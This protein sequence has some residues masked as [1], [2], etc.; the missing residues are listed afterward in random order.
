VENLE[1]VDHLFSECYKVYAIWQEYL[2]WLECESP[3]PKE[4][5]VH[6]EW[7][8]GLC[9]VSSKKLHSLWSCIWI[10]VTWE[11]WSVRNGINFQNLTFDLNKVTDIIRVKAWQRV[12]ENCEVKE[13]HFCFGK[14]LHGLASSYDTR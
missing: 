3:V 14:H 13:C 1:T 10:V 4:A 2:Y 5:T 6:S 7:L 9:K 12:K 11:I 8:M